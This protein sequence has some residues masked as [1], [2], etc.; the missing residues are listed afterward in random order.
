MI[1]RIPEH[2][3]IRIEYFLLYFPRT[4]ILSI[5]KTT[6]TNPSNDPSAIRNSPVLAIISTNEVG[7]IMIRI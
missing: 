1:N 2:T 4:K 6:P 7:S 5:P 3:M